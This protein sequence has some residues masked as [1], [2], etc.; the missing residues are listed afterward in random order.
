MGTGSGRITA[1]Q[2]RL[3]TKRC[4]GHECGE[5]AGF[6]IVAW[7]PV[8]EEIHFFAAC[9]RHLYA[10]AHWVMDN[11]TE[12]LDVLDDG[13]WQAALDGKLFG[14]GFLREGRLA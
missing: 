14:A 3:E 12:D 10:M 2:L 8:E 1:A 11:V 13:A 4:Y 7:G 9:G 5:P 6:V